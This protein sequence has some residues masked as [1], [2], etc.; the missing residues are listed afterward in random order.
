MKLRKW[1]NFLSLVFCDFKTKEIRSLKRHCASVQ[2]NNFNR[3]AYS[4]CD[5]DNTRNGNILMAI[6]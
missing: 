6:T 2:P 3:F 1:I 4:N 5:K